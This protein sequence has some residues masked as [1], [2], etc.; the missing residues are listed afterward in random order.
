VPGHVDYAL[1]R[2]AVLREYRRGA[3]TRLDVCDAHPELLRAGRH[4]GVAAQR[5][6]PICEG[7]DV[8]LVSY[9][10]GDKLR[11]ANGR[12]IGC[13][14][15][16]SKLGAAHDEFACYVVEVCLGCSWNHLHRR[17]LLGR[18]H[19]PEARITG[20]GTLRRPSPPVRRAEKS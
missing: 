2:R 4:L 1:A 17:Y 7:D 12:C 6:C 11:R 10:Y 3:L 13:D 14:A 9:V 15:V 19:A 5:P 18:R 16:L 8:R 20:V